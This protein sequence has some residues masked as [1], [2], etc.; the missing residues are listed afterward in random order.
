MN[1]KEQETVTKSIINAL[2][3]VPGGEAIGILEC[4]KL[5]I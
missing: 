2:S 3:G 4:V 1:T 5:A